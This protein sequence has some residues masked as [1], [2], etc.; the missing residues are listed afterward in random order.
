[1]GA[2][3]MLPAGVAAVG[4]AEP[5]P[6]APTTFNQ[7]RR[8]SG[9]C[10]MVAY[11]PGLEEQHPGLRGSGPGLGEDPGLPARV[12]PIAGRHTSHH[13]LRAV[14]TE[15]GDRATAPAARDLGAEQA[16]LWTLRRDELDEAIGAVAAEP[17]CAIA[18]VRLVHQVPE[19][20]GYRG[21]FGDCNEQLGETPHSRV[22]A[23]GV[24]GGLSHRVA[25]VGSD[26][27][28]RIGDPVVALQELCAGHLP[29]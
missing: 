29:G 4:R 7:S 2:R 17:A 23:Y 19:L 14:G 21:L 12:R 20:G 6:A 26:R 18:L 1:M 13:V 16:A 10:P 3:P 27:G 28:D 25:P 5:A 22:L 15:D 9:L 24:L 8:D 11:L